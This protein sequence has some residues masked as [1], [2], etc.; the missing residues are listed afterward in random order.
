MSAGAGKGGQPRIELE[1]VCREG[2]KTEVSLEDRR[3]Q[4]EME[5]RKKS[6]GSAKQGLVNGDREVQ[7]QRGAAAQAVV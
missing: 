5:K 2:G 7:K 3:N 1:G 6:E 4:D